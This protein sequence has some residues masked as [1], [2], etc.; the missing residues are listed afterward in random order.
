MAATLTQDRFT[1]PEWIFERKFDGIRLIAFKNGADVRLF[2][3]NRLP[4]NGSYPAVA[5]AIANL[6]VHD[7]ILD[8]EA[9]GGWERFGSADYY[10][11]DVLWL[12]G[13][14]LTALPLDE[15]RAVARS[16]CHCNCRSSRWPRLDA[17][18]P[19]ER[20]C[21]EGWEGVIA[22]R[23]DSTYEHRRSK[24]WL[25]MKC[26]STAGLRRRRLHRSAGQARRPRRAARRL[27]RSRG[28]VLRRK[29]WHRL[30][31]RA[32]AGSARAS[33]CARDSEDA[34]HE[35]QGAAAPARALGA[36]RDCR[37]GGLHR[38]DRARQA[39]PSPAARRAPDR[40]AGTV[41]RQ[42]RAGARRRS[43]SVNADEKSARSQA[44]GRH[45]RDHSSRES[46]VPS[47]RVA[48]RDHQGRAGGLLRGDRA[49]HRA[50][51]PR[52]A[53]HDGALSRRHRQEGLH[54]EGRRRRAFPSWLERVEVPKKDGTVHHAIVTDTRSLLWI[55]NQNTITPHVWSA[56]APDLYHPD[57]C[58]FDLDPSDRRCGDAAL[59]GAWPARLP[60]R[61]SACPAG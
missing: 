51:H 36:S 54:P 55:V 56:R 59:R 38:M 37:R 33:G 31:Q 32:A 6:P 11:F 25:K 5:Q 4:L 2:S 41:H 22:K 10:V 18:D 39:A 13:R 21:A 27:L 60:G 49:R 15:R 40:D 19:W 52:P 24:S 30:R 46:A 48:L 29:D 16:I 28:I 57:I 8:G 1:G 26:E 61:S 47:R 20:A 17:R 35:G 14:D 45:G 43:K 34:V 44:A 53:D 9:V 12:N 23:R 50:A 58:V 3:R 42:G 7:V